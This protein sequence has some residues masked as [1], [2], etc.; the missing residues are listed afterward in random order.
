MFFDRKVIVYSMLIVL[1]AGKV[2]YY[3][4]DTSLK[5]NIMHLKI[6]SKRAKLN[7]IVVG[8]VRC[9][10]VSHTIFFEHKVL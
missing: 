4:F 5:N 3:F 9:E 6:I 2:N 7:V 1:Y 10:K 8:G